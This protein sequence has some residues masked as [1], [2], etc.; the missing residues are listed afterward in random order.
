MIGK[1]VSLFVKDHYLRELVHLESFKEG[2]IE[3][4]LIESFHHIDEMLNKT[5]CAVDSFSI[6]CVPLSF[7]LFFSVSLSFSLSISLSYTLINISTLSSSVSS[8]IVITHILISSSPLI[9]CSLP[10]YGA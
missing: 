6:F 4:A 2:N 7:F 10:H 1:E 8:S 9:C 3:A 5:V